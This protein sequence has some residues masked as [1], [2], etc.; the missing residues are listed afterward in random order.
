MKFKRR[1]PVE[2]GLTQID[3]VPF[4]TIAFLLII[5]FLLA[6]RLVMTPG[7]AVKM[8]KLLTSDTLGP[9]ALSVVIDSHNELRIQGAQKTFEEFAAFV[10]AGRFI[11]VFIQA[12]ARADLGTI[13]R[14][15]QLCQTLGI[16]R[17]GLA[18][19]YDQ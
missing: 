9:H 2:A 16:E 15:Y 14:I 8:P 12:D 10:K 3:L 18:T 11:A 4:I 7:M 19:T 1:L 5:F 6:T 17:I 13:G